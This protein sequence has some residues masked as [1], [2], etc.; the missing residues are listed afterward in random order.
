MSVF[1]TKAQIDAQGVHMATAIGNKIREF[2]SS[3]PLPESSRFLGTFLTSDNIPLDK[4]VA[5]SYADVD[6]GSGETVTR[7]IYDVDSGAFV[8][9]AGE[10][11]GETS[12]SVKEKYESNPN[13][14]A[15]TDSL[16]S[17]LESLPTEGAKGEKGADGLQGQS[18]YE[19]AVSLGYIGS[20]EE[21]LNSLKGEKGDPFLYIDFT[22]EQLEALKGDR[23]K[24][25]E[26]GINATNGTVKNQNTGL[27]TKIWIGTQQEYDDL[28]IKDSD[29]LYMVK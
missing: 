10:V 24:Q 4:A 13:T 11:A 15:F 12:A 25:G 6:A 3:L 28:I 22:T 23:G 2:V 17:K 20:E 7:W 5:G 26:A 21:W 29:T 16:R 14:N 18:T 9:A 27:D 1:Y 19:L 8:P